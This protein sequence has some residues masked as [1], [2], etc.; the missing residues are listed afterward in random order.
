MLKKL[1]VAKNLNQNNMDI[2]YRKEVRLLRA[3]HERDMQII[4]INQNALNDFI[5]VAE[6]CA[7]HASVRYGAVNLNEMVLLKQAL[8][9]LY[10]KHKHLK[11]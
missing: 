9:K 8:L 3:C 1:T 10:F 7:G 6:Q 2:F 11:K 5:K 4:K